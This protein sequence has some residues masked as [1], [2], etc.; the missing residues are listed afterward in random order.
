MKQWKYSLK[1]EV[2]WVVMICCLINKNC[3]SQN[4]DYSSDNSYGSTIVQ[5]A[6]GLTTGRMDGRFEPRGRGGGGDFSL[7][8]NHPDWLWGP[9][10]HPY[11]INWLC[12]RGKVA[13]AWC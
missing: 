5:S 1:I 11:N 4:T 2:F 8:Y 10:S 3:K 7:I 9:F 6:K 12:P 13:T